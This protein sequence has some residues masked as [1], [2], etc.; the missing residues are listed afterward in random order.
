M[1]DKFRTAYVGRIIDPLSDNNGLWWVAVDT[2]DGKQ[3]IVFRD[4]YKKVCIY[5]AKQIADKVMVQKFCL[6]DD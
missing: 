6:Y 2:G 1:S 4:V 3:R 5:H